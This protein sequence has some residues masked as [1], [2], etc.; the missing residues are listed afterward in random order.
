MKKIIEFS[1]SRLKGYDFRFDSTITSYHLYALLVTKFFCYIRGAPIFI[2]G[3]S[4]TVP[5][6]GRGVKFFLHRNVKFGKNVS[7]GDF[8]YISG[9]GAKGVF[10]GDNVNIG[11]FSRLVV[12]VS[13]NNIGSHITIMDN[14]SIGE[15]SYIG[16]AGGVDIESDT[17]IGQYFSV[18][19]ENHIYSNT[20]IPIRLQGV[21]RKGIRVGS[22]CWIGAK[23]TLLDGVS[24]GKNCVVAAGAVV[25]TNFPD[26]VT[27]AGVPARIIKSR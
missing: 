3:N 8:C 14:V 18:H 17:I 26:N 27:I 10:L 6:C 19:P 1:I 11:G 21:T 22:N 13:F 4:K 25:T 23:V 20:E 5:F 15:Y 12:S 16:G 24:I 9:L 2:R 7:L